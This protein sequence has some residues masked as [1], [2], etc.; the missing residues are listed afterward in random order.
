MPT[1]YPTIAADSNFHTIALEVARNGAPMASLGTVVSISVKDSD[2]REVIVPENTV[3]SASSIAG[4][5]EYRFTPETVASI[6]KHGVWL[7]EWKISYGAYTWR[8]PEPAQ[9]PVRKKL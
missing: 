5:W 3:V 8:L 1:V 4:R 7:V 6:T 2:T 9:Q